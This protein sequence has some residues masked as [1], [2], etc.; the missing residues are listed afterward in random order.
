MKPVAIRF[1]FVSTQQHCRSS[2]KSKVS[3]LLSLCLLLFLI[4]KLFL[5][6][7]IDFNCVE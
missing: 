7:S 2:F 1:V 5:S 6:E 3:E 4:I